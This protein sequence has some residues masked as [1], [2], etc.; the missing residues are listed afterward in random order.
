MH[1]QVK[2]PVQQYHDRGLA[3]SHTSNLADI[4][5]R[6][7]PNSRPAVNSNKAHSTCAMDRALEQATGSSPH[8]FVWIKFSGAALFSSCSGERL[9]FAYDCS[10]VSTVTDGHGVFVFSYIFNYCFIPS[11]LRGKKVT[12]KPEKPYGS[13]T[14]IWPGVQSRKQPLLTMQN[15]R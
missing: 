3:C 14:T 8:V 2:L 10:K 11:T 13:N 12:G 7:R 15:R 5:T 4:Y 6:R 1:R 9:Y